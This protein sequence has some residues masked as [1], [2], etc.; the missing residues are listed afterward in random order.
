MGE[1]PLG[2]G[3]LQRVL[4][5]TITGEPT[6]LLVTAG[7]TADHA[8]R[9]SGDRHRLLCEIYGAGCTGGRICRQRDHRRLPGVNLKPDDSLTAFAEMENAGAG[10]RQRLSSAARK[11]SKCHDGTVNTV[12]FVGQSCGFQCCILCYRQTAF[13]L[14]SYVAS[15]QA[16]FRQSPP[17]YVP[18][19]VMA[20]GLY[21]SPAF[22]PLLF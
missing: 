4:A 9:C 11:N 12:P 7:R 6:V 21:K 1:N 17:S 15:F 19:R 22:R 13:Q 18:I 10:C 8:S 14:P 3:Q 16:D 5:I 20:S 2:H